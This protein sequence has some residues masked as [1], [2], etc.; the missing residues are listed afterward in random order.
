MSGILA[1][2]IGYGSDDPYI[3]DIPPIR[4]CLPTDVSHVTLL[5]LEFRERGNLLQFAHT[6]PGVV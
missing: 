6:T 4:L 5:Y 1:T 2:G 3:R